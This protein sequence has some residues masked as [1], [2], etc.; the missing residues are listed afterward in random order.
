MKIKSKSYSFILTAPYILSD[1]NTVIKDGAIFISDGNIADIGDYAEITIRH[2]DI[3]VN[4]QN[5]S[6]LL[7]GLVNAH[8]HLEYSSLGRMSEPKDFIPWIEDLIRRQRTFSEEE[9]ISSIQDSINILIASGITAI[10]EISK[11]GASIG[12]V[13]T[14]GMKGVLF[15]ELVALDNKKNIFDVDHFRTTFEKLKSQLFKSKMKPGIFPHSPYTISES[16]LQK[17]SDFYDTER[18]N[19]GMHLFESQCEQEFVSSAS[20]PLKDF[21]M[22]YSLDTAPKKGRWRDPIDYI[23]SL[24]YFSPETHLVHLA[25]IKE[26]HLSLIEEKNVGV[27]LCPRSNHLLKNGPFPFK[28][29]LNYNLKMG[30]GTDSLA[31]NFSFDMFEEMRYLKALTND[32]ISSSS[33]L[34]SS[35]INKKLL[36]MATLGGAKVLSIDDNTGSLS[37][38]KSADLIAVK[39][40]DDLLNQEEFSPVDYI[41]ERATPDD[42]LLTMIN[43][44]ITYDAK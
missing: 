11:N 8:I 10:G 16:V 24:G 39:I 36:N 23:N 12:E 40:N 31:S 9:I 38:G 3:P 19:L 25:Y 5:N 43:G 29:S 21:S 26:H 15:T 34:S 27:V 6:I 37:V 42:V 14:S 28:Q 41:V 13:V 7:P 30:I 4:M 17:I 22:K 35:D 32:G 2:S 20:G 33:A 44:E 1:S 18:V